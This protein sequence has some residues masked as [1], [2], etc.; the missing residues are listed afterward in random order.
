MVRWARVWR[1]RWWGLGLLA[2]FLVAQWSPYIALASLPARHISS[3]RLTP[4]SPLLAQLREL[5]DQ[6]ISLPNFTPDVNGF[7]FSNRELIDAIDWEKDAADW[8][9]VLTEQLEKLFGSRVCTGGGEGPCVLTAAA[10]DWLKTQLQRMDLGI[11]EGMATAALALWQPE[12][13][14][15]IPWW[16]RLVNFLLGRTVFGLV[17]TVFEL[18]TFIANFFL[19]QSVEE[20]FQP[21]Q[22]IRDTL[23]PTQ[24]LL[25]ILEVFLTGSLDPFTMG[26]YRVIESGLTEG[27]TL[28]PY[29]VE[30]KGDGKYWVYVY[31]SNYPAARS[32][33]LEDLHV[34]FD[35]AADTWSYQPTSSDPVFKGDAL[36][37]TLDL[38]HL[39]WRQLGAGNPPA[40]EQGPFTCP[41]CDQQLPEA[42][43]EP[44]D[45][46]PQI[47]VTLIGEGDMTV[48]PLAGT[49]SLSPV[50][51]SGKETLVPFRGGLY[52]HVPASYTLPAEYLNQPLQVILAGLPTV[53]PQP[54]ALQLTGPGYTADIEGITMATGEPLM[55]YLDPQATGPELTFVARQATEIPTLSV[56]LNDDIQAYQFDSSTAEGF[57]QTERRVAKS[58][59][60][61]VRGLKLPAGKRVGL[62]ARDDLKRLY[63][64][65][66]DGQ[67][68]RYGL[69]VKNRMVIRDRIQLGHQNPDFIHYTLTYEE[70]LQASDLRV[71]AQTQAFFDYVPAFI[72]PGNRPREEL[73]AA[74]EQR[75]FPIT[76]AYEPL[77]ATSGAEGPMALRP[78]S[79]PP[80]SQRV[81]QGALRKAGPKQH[82]SSEDI[83]PEGASFRRSPLHR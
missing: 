58:S 65:D 7:Q 70:E 68:S 10:Q 44:A 3:P 14:A 63:F 30:D 50:I 80:L 28:T 67:D 46:A 74:F 45:T 2:T 25:S 49:T 27:H 61:E 4:E 21:T 75:D 36:S 8:E 19:L 35:T 64:A 17:R 82:R 39:S 55:L 51:P 77:S 34:V 59:G 79:D 66:D 16:Q 1:W 78:S 73:I 71:E 31:D 57:A 18:Q 81:F 32:V 24:I 41:F 26:V 52:R 6:T 15:P 76:L 33:P 56:H 37:K 23:A 83:K 53:N 22:V 12:P 47:T 60:F 9:T 72:E 40:A 11:A 54:M 48:I 38:S 43:T 69:T 13:Q 42:G 29:K 62:A 5:P 20:V